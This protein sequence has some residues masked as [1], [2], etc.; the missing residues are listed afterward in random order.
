M[1]KDKLGLWSLV[2]IG[3]SSM[4]GSGWLFSAYYAAKYAGSGAYI[5][6]ILSFILVLFF[7]LIIAEI[8]TFYPKRGLFTRLLTLS[9]NHDVGY[10]TALANWLGVIAVVPAE[11]EATIQYLSNLK[12]NWTPYLFN[13]GQ[14]T[15]IGLLLCALLLFIYYLL[16]FWGTR[17]FAKAN[18]F[19]TVFKTVVPILTGIALFLAVFHPSNFT[20][21]HHQLLPY[22][23]YSIFGVV[24]SSGMI[25]TF[26]GFQS[27]ASFCTETNQPETLIPRSMI[28][29][30]SLCLGI[31][32]LLQTA[33][34]GSLPP[35]YIAHGWH[36]LVFTSPF[37]ELT[38]LL[39]LTIISVILYINVLVSPSGSALVFTA[40]ST[41][42][43]TA[44]S[45]E[46]QAPYFFHHLHPKYHFSRRSLSFNIFL[47]FIL[48]LIFHSWQEIAAVI[49]LL[50]IISYMACPISLMRLRIN[51]PH[52]PRPY[53]L[54]F[55][56]FLSPL[57]FALVTIL[58]CSAIT[59]YLMLVSSVIILFYLMYISV[60]Y[61]WCYE[62]MIAGL[63]RSYMFPAYFIVLN[64]LK[65][66]TLIHHYQMILHIIFYILTIF[67][68]FVFYSWM[69]YFYRDQT[70]LRH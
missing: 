45:Q 42:M 34:I 19:V 13:H 52:Q 49:S 54:P 22:G 35:A 3:V 33:F 47:C 63:R 62:K 30:I 66:L 16:N 25:Y 5:S 32:L 9:H 61:R 18:N 10:I 23:V 17:S 11:S 56:P 7:S 59:Y 60:H 51:E 31:Y 37:V 58:F 28:I 53:R 48:L 15:M 57:L 24:M 21:F 1:I 67:V 50:H 2:A 14:L 68:S 40:T 39:G 8:V 55:A 6:W 26:N 43:L 46:Q 27:I 70:P 4:L 36:H 29:A 64:L 41:R 38:S 44:M 69:V 20:G 65:L 12:P